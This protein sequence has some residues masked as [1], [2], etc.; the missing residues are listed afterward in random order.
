MDQARASR[1]DA[2]YVVGWYADPPPEARIPDGTLDRVL[3]RPVR[4]FADWVRENR[5]RF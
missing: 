4:R 2:E 1:A 3:G 5:D